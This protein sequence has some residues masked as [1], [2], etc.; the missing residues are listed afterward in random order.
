MAKELLTYS[1]KMKTEVVASLL[2]IFVP[3]SRISSGSLSKF[4]QLFL[5]HDL[6]TAKIS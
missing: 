3:K 4:K 6:P 1:Q 2:K 5:A